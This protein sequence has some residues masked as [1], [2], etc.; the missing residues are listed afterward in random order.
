M[1]TQDA[2][3]VQVKYRKV[4]SDIAKRLGEVRAFWATRDAILQGKPLWDHEAARLAGAGYFGP[5]KFNAVQ[6]AIAGGVAA[7]ATKFLNLVSP[8]TDAPAPQH[9]PDDPAFSKLFETTYGWIDPFVV[10]VY[11]TAFVFFMGWGSV[12]KAQSTATNRARSRAAYLY[13]D[14]AH[15]FWPQVLLAF[16]FAFAASPLG[17]RLTASAPSPALLLPG[18]AIVGVLLLWQFHITGGRIPKLLFKVHNYSARAR[19]FWQPRKPDDPPWSKLVT[20]NL[21]AAWPLSLAVAGS[22]Y[23]LAYGLAQLLTWLRRLVG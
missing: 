12:W 14:G 19:R 18:Y 15:G 9:F 7:G 3:P 4:R 11:F 20:A 16:I 21:L 6:S 5:W 8:R 13:L 17:V 22:A 23:A 10:P 2:S 1:E